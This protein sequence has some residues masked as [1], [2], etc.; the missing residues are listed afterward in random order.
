M[1]CPAVVIQSEKQ[2]PDV[3]AGAILVPTKPG[4]DTVR[5]A[6]VLDLEHGALAGL[7]DGIEA[8]RNDPVKARPF[9]P[10]EPVP[11][12]GPVARRGRQ[13]DRRLRGLERTFEPL[14]PLA[15]RDVAKVLLVE[16]EDVPCD[17]AGR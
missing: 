10:R 15:L 8:L 12:E 14:A 16:G 2:R 17:E 11:G 13:V 5:C 7:V 3:R 1:E 9:E 6:L 4:H